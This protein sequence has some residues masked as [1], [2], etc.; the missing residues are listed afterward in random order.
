[1]GI[2]PRNAYGAPVLLELEQLQA[3]DM[4]MRISMPC[5]VSSV[6][7]KLAAR[8]ESVRGAQQRRAPAEAHIRAPGTDAHADAH[9]RIIHAG[10]CAYVVHL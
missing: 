8:R 6:P 4:H 1:M 2:L 7:G 10:A 9:M 3:F 5:A